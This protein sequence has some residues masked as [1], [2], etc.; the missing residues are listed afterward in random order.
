VSF[1]HLPEYE[2][3]TIAAALD[4][5]LEHREQYNITAVNLSPLDDNEHTS[6]V[7]TAIDA[8]LRLL[9]QAGVWVSAPCGNNEHTKGISWPACALDCFAIGASVPVPGPRTAHL[10]RWRNTELLVPATATSSSN[11]FAVGAFMCVR[12]AIVASGFEWQAHPDIGTSCDNIADAIMRIFQWSGRDVYDPATDCCFRE[13]DVLSALRYVSGEGRGLQWSPP[14][15][16]H[17]RAR[18]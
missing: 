7:P 5:V 18:M 14:P 9:R 15:P 11:A 4:W 8:P 6:S 2:D 3:D 16:V 12:E 13:L 17:D 1:V 10:D